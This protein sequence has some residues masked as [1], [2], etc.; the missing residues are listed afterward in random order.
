MKSFLTILLSLIFSCLLAQPTITFT[1]MPA[2]GDTVRTSSTTGGL[3]INYQQTG[4]NYT[5][6]FSSLSST[7]TGA[8][9]FI[10]VTST[11]LVYNLAFNL[12]SPAATRANLASP[13][14]D[15]SLI[16][17]LPLTDIFN[18]FKSS[19]DSY[20]MCGFGAAISGI[21][22]PIK[23]NALDV[24]Y[25]FPLTSTSTADSSE[26]YFAQGIPAIGYLSIQRK[27]VNTVDGWGT[28]IT[29]AGSYPALRLKS[30][31]RETDS[32]YVDSLNIGFSVPRNYTEYKWLANG[33]G[34]PVMKVSNENIIPTFTWIDSAA[35]SNP[36]SVDAGAD[37]SVCEGTSVQ[38]TATAIGGTPPY[39]YLWSNF[40]IGPTIT[41]SPSATTTY[42]V[43][44]TDA[45][46]QFATDA[47]TVTVIPELIVDITLNPNTT[48]GCSGPPP[49]VTVFGFTATPGYFNYIWSTGVSGPGVNVTSSGPPFLGYIGSQDYTV[50]VSDQNGCYGQN[51]V[52]ISW[53]TCNGIEETNFAGTSFSMY[54]NPGDGIVNIMYHNPDHPVCKIEVLNS[55]GQFI[56]DIIPGNFKSGGDIQTFDLRSYTKRHG[57]FFIRLIS[58]QGSLVKPLMIE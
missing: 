34:I 9:T 38:I 58:D 19:S 29:P 4:S 25:M 10:S 3:G 20:A 35:V 6:D 30:V 42:S 28:V 52:S 5:W 22:I 51:T 26:V 17:N 1:D 27:R 7:N 18:F 48:T 47:I 23:F 37:Q 32:I 13:Q 21:T 46:F 33:K 45:D 15:F 54:P 40:T 16:P 50:T 55:T 24:W 14:A 2:I 56:G 8:D 39:Y 11:P 49:N 57:L 31:V 36:F 41:V 43:T 44:A 53:T 12:L